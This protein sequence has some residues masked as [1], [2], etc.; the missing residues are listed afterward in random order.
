MKT[1]T[2]FLTKVNKAISLLNSLY[3]GESFQMEIYSLCKKLLFISNY[4]SSPIQKKQFEQLLRY[5][6]QKINSMR[7]LLSKFKMG[8]SLNKRVDILQRQ[9]MIYAIIKRTNVLYSTLKTNFILPHFSMEEM[10]EETS[11]RK[12]SLTINTKSF[13]S[14][15]FQFDSSDEDTKTKS[16]SRSSSIDL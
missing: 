8:V 14:S 4:I 2:T 12:E 6:I 16:T 1:K 7:N 13:I 10:R 5:I 9:K 3:Y 15:F 11:K